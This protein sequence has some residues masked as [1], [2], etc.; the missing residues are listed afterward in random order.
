MFDYNAISSLLESRVGFVQSL[1]SAFNLLPDSMLTAESGLKL[2][3]GLTEYLHTDNIYTSLLNYDLLP[4]DEWSSLESYTTGKKL[5]HNGIAWIATADSTDEEPGSVSGANFWET[6]FASELRKKR[7]EGIKYAII[8]LFKQHNLQRYQKTLFDFGVLFPTA[9]NP[10]QRPKQGR[11]I[12]FLIK[13]CADFV[14]MDL[15][16]IGLTYSNVQELTFYI[17]HSSKKTAIDTVTVNIEANNQDT[18]VWK[19]IN[20]SLQNYSDTHSSTGHF[21]I[22]FFEDDLNGTLKQWEQLGRGYIH[23]NNGQAVS[24][25]R[26]I[27][28]GSN[29]LNGIE[30]PTLDEYSENVNTYDYVP[31]N[32]KV[33]IKTDPTELFTRIPEQ[34]DQVLQLSIAHKVL[35]A[36]HENISLGRVNQKNDS[37]VNQLR[38]ELYGN[39]QMEIEGIEQ[40]LKKAI[41]QCSIN[42]EDLETTFKDNTAYY[43]GKV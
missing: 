39:K 13:P 6:L 14:K 7:I 11:F 24:Y 12:G 18:F 37:S 3:E 28:I 20:K 31:F 35:K 38:L 41:K 10:I 21:L 17:F 23:G 15:H 19:S 22:G 29:D 33:S 34:F 8:E 25:V 30:L 16:Q 36:M 40:R 42:L 26:N 9:S 5:V 27:E 2:N 1:E 4:S 43:E 32:L